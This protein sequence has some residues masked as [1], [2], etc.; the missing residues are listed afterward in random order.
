MDSLISKSNLKEFLQGQVSRSDTSRVMQPAPNYKSLA[1]LWARI[2][3]VLF[4][5]I[6]DW[7]YKH[8]DPG[9]IDEL[10]KSGVD[11][12][13]VT[14]LLAAS[15]LGLSDLSDIRNLLLGKLSQVSSLYKDKLQKYSSAT[16]DLADC[17]TCHSSGMTCIISGERLYIKGDEL[18]R[19]N[20][21]NNYLSTRSRANGYTFWCYVNPMNRRVLDLQTYKYLPQPVSEALNH[22]Y[23]V[24]KTYINMKYVRSRSVKDF[25]VKPLSSQ[26]YSRLM[27]I[28][29][30]VSNQLSSVEAT[31]SSLPM[32]T[33]LLSYISSIAK[34]SETYLEFLDTLTRDD[35]ITIY[36]FINALVSRIASQPLTSR[37]AIQL[38]SPIAQRLT[39]QRGEVN[40]RRNDVEGVKVSSVRETAKSAGSPFNSVATTN[41][42]EVKGKVSVK[43][44]TISSKTTIA[45][46][47]SS[48]GDSDDSDGQEDTDTEHASEDDAR[49]S[50]N[51]DESKVIKQLNQ[52]RS[53]LDQ[54]PR[55]EMEKEK[56][57]STSSSGKTRSSKSIDDRGRTGVRTS[58]VRAQGTKT[59]KE[60]LRPTRNRR[61]Q[62]S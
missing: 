55:N 34:N 16:S 26:T 52:V 4:R 42:I 12:Y 10:A 59:K 48:D 25:R 3:D 32:S 6:T 22:Y 33:I 1:W 37:K 27:A 28:D 14:L 39:E 31:E 18:K 40:Q 11:S 17:Y 7:I 45:D 21:D 58:A 20:L 62:N 24:A 60:S 44:S 15:I 5:S 29:R 61:R 54:M 23:D 8:L 9:K 53:Q 47:D 41:L 38:D 19:L 49:S 51:D 35:L 56:T 43:G 36:N 13:P 30:A 57:K 2:D 46:D 50:S